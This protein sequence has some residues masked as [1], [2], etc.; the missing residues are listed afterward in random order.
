MDN[1][2]KGVFKVLTESLNEDNIAMCVK[3]EGK[4][5]LEQNDLCRKICGDC[6]GEACERGCM[7]LYAQDD[8]HQW[9]E[10]GSRV[11]KNKWM[12]GAFFDVTLLCTEKHIITFLQPL[13]EKYEMALEFYKSKGLTRRETEVVSFTIRGI[14]NTEICKRLSISRATL[15][16]HLNNVYR[17]FRELGET[18][19]FIPA[20]R[21]Q[22]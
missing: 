22:G 6:V 8:S 1:E 2:Q 10:W 16:T 21:L 20:N 13:K 11:Y 14:S 4:R 7:E 15:R 12:H 3:D 9:K 18:P 19:D 5:V 17:K